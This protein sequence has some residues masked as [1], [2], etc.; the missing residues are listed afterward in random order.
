[1]AP[2]D[3]VT[4]SVAVADIAA[5]AAAVL[6]ARPAEEGGGGWA[7]AGKTYELI[8]DAPSHD[9]T[10]AAL[11]A[12]VPRPAVEEADAATR[13]AAPAPSGVLYKQVPAAE[14][15]AAAMAAGVPEWT[16]SS[17]VELAAATA[18]GAVKMRTTSGDL[19]AL[20]G[21]ERGGMDVATWA[22]S[23]ADAWAAS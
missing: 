14:A 11:S 17:L 5:A 12:V 20:L 19:R 15:V 4:P 16:A 10:A 23:T 18:S 1:M 8:S 22:R 7:H 3:A 21:G 9:A 6:T 13:D 2:P